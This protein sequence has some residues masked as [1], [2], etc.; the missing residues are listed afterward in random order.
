MTTIDHGNLQ[1]IAAAATGRIA[2]SA[3]SEDLNT[4]LL[5]LRPGESVD[6][7]RN[8]EVDVLLVTIA[9]EGTITIAGE[10][11]PL[12]PGVAVIIPKGTER[13]MSSETSLAYLTCHKQRRGLWPTTRPQRSKEPQ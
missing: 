11:H 6:T 13:A 1:T 5:T 9:G 7:H 2:W 10:Q 4:N 12:S 8:D 3:S